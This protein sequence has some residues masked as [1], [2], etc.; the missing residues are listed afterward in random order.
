MAFS[1]TSM[2]RAK[3]ATI[4]P[5]VDNFSLRDSDI[6][7]NVVGGS[8]RCLL[9][10][11]GRQPLERASSMPSR[12]HTPP[13]SYGSTLTMCRRSAKP[14]RAP[15]AT[16]ALQPDIVSLTHEPETDEK[17]SDDCKVGIGGPPGLSDVAVTV[18][19]AS[20]AGSTG[21]I[22]TPTSTAAHRNLSSTSFI[23]RRKRVSDFGFLKLS[24][25]F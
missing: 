21:R 20:T 17:R 25:E 10:L 16:T 2:H 6:P 13:P 14:R 23:F 18:S 22:P 5:N 11:N 24:W 4:Q 15:S 8:G 19:P 3:S 7:L 12:I 1:R 9:E